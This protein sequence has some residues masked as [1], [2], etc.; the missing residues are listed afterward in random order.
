MRLLRTYRK[1]VVQRIILRALSS[2]TA[3]PS[4]VFVHIN[5]VVL[6]H[7]LRIIRL[8]LCIFDPICCQCPTHDSRPAGLP[9]QFPLDTLLRRF[10]FLR[11]A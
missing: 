9:V 10:R 11:K 1:I 7:L 5:V 2:L 6:A 8:R 3:Y 4:G